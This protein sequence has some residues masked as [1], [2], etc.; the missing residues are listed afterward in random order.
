VTT[1]LQARVDESIARIAERRAQAQY[2]P[3]M[4]KRQPIAER[5]IFVGYNPDGSAS[6]QVEPTGEINCARCTHIGDFNAE[7]ERGWCM[8]RRNMV[9]T[10]H[11]A[12]CKAFAA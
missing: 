1:S 4:E 12:R 5:R 6:E 9:S 8:W 10:W 3:I 7:H 11:P 2:E